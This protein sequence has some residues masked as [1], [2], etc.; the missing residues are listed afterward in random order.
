LQKKI[1]LE[2][3]RTNSTPKQSKSIEISKNL[4]SSYH[5]KKSKIWFSY[6][7]SIEREEGREES[8]SFLRKKGRMKNL[9]RAV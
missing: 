7:K 9:S 8:L 2:N 1:Y 6:Y 5:I 3:L 4:V